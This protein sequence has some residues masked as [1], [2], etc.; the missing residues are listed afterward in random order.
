[1]APV[2]PPTWFRKDR[3]GPARRSKIDSPKWRHRLRST[4]TST[5][6]KRR[7]VKVGM[8]VFNLPKMP[9]DEDGSGN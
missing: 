1:M 3:S 9:E 2:L 4:V 5:Q 8:P 6:V 7:N